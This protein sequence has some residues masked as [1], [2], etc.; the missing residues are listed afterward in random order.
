MLNKSQ[1]LSELDI[2]T[3]LSGGP[4]GQH[5]NKTETKVIVS[6][7]YLLSEALTD[8]EKKRLTKQLSAS[9]TKSQQIKINSSKTR[10]QHKNKQDA[11]DKLY[12]LVA[13]ALKVPKKRKRTKPS[14]LA[15][16][17]RLKS[18]KKHSEKKSLRKKPKI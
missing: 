11:I 13:Q 3:S 18:K 14:K 1:F 10:S 6:W 12:H 2:Q 17:K 15:K 16:L 9:I 7:R 5:V 8:F 4:G